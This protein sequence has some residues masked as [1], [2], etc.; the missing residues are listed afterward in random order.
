ME[1]GKETVQSMKLETAPG[2]VLN[3]QDILRAAN[4]RKILCGFFRLDRELPDPLKKNRSDAPNKTKVNN[5]RYPNS[6]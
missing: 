4:P 2:H 5:E 6:N 3:S 1:I